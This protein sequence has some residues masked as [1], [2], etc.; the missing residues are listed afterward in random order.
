MRN[1]STL[2][3]SPRFAAAWHT[4]AM[5]VGSGVRQDGNFGH[6]TLARRYAR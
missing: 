1:R 6:V 4:L 3:Y 5:P 2:T